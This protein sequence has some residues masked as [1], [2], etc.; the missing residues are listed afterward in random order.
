M[1]A[2]SIFIKDQ[3][4]MKR[5][6]TISG[7]RALPVNVIERIRQRNFFDDDIFRGSNYSR[8]WNSNNSGGHFNFNRITPP[9]PENLNWGG[10]FKRDRSPVRK[11]R[12]EGLNESTPELREPFYRPIEEPPFRDE[13]V[14][15]NHAPINFDRDEGRESI[16]YRRFNTN[17]TEPP[18][19][20]NIF[21][22]D[23]ERREF[24]NENYGN[25][26]QGEFSNENFRNSGQP[27]FPNENFQNSGQPELS[28][29]N[30][31]INDQPE[32]SNDRLGNNGQSVTKTSR[33]IEISDKVFTIG[34]IK[35]PYVTNVI[36]KAP[37]TDG[38]SYFVRYV[39]RA[40]NYI[41]RIT[42]TKEIPIVQHIY[43]EIMDVN[44]DDDL[45]SKDRSTN[46]SMSRYRESF[47]QEWTK[48]YRGRNYRTWEGWW[49]DFRNIDVDILEQLEKFD[50]FNVKWNF[51]MP[52]GTRDTAEL[53]K[54]ANIALTKNKNNYLG[55]MK[56][57][58]SLM[59]HN[60]LGNLDMEATAQLQD[61]IRLVPN[62]LWIYK[63]RGMIYLW[64]NY[65]QV[66]KSKD[67]GDKK[68]QMVL[69]EWKSPVIHW[70]AHQAFKELRAISQTEYPQFREV[71][72]ADSKVAK[73]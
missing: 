16:A 39:K 42:N 67:T 71:Y 65:S 6:M 1:S 27:E 28:N 29:E 44:D 35:M 37:F 21:N 2:R 54:R 59:D 20:Y 53:I 62:H 14:I 36:G 60:I 17:F 13:P 70:V 46:F 3:P 47:S 30:F 10:M 52:G 15:G 24:S 50:C 4:I 55:N 61:I 64:Y 31:G 32:F 26:G 12:F 19:G 72:G 5:R 57:I 43:N 38:K 9:P 25:G 22:N 56:V 33:Y 18:S 48:I 45:G 41:I 11:V 63:L 40:P 8:G 51:M 23:L 34:G 58:Y 7:N 66:M 68:Y 69:K 73:K 49:K